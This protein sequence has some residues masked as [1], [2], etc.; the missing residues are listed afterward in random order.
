MILKSN[1]AGE[2]A[3]S[4]LWNLDPIVVEITQIIFVI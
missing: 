3:A 4:C 2:V 1:V